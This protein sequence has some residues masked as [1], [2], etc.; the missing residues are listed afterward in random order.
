M[1]DMSTFN[2]YSLLIVHF[3]VQYRI[4][5]N[6]L[7]FISFHYKAD[8]LIKLNIRVL[9]SFHYKVDNHIKLNIIV[10]LY[11]LYKGG[12]RIKLN[13]VVFISFHYKAECIFYL[14]IM[15]F[16]YGEGCS[17]VV[18]QLSYKHQIQIYKI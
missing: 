14:P 15:K 11:F 7:V 2:H 17:T 10:L 16:K 8:N 9:L 4:K 12:Y 18:E 1:V 5:L 3:K 6:I 13:I